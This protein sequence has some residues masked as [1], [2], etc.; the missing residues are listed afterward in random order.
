M[1]AGV[2]GIQQP[3]RAFT[4]VEL[5]VV[6]AIIAVLIGLLLPAVQSARE[7]ARRTQCGNNLRQL[8]LGMITYASANKDTFPKNRHQ[9][10]PAADTWRHWEAF[11]ANYRLL[12][13]LEE[14]ALY[15]RFGFGGT[16]ASYYSGPMQTKVA[17]FLCPSA[18]PAPPVTRISWGG[19]GC[20]YAWCN[21]SGVW[22]QQNNQDPR[23]H[24][25]IIHTYFNRRA[26]Q[27]TDGLTKTLLAAEILP[28]TGFS[29]G[30][31]GNPVGSATYPYDVFYAGE[32]AFSA[33]ADKAFPTRAE[34]AAVGAAA[35]G[36]AGGGHRG[37]NGCLWGWYALSHTMFNTAA[38]PDW[39]YPT[40]GGSCCPGGATDW[41]SNIVPPRSMHPGGVSA[42]MGDGSVRLINGS[43]DPLAF[44]RM[45]NIRD[46]QVISE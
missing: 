39:E 14:V 7:S 33:M 42:A 27:V 29:S 34:L 17:A 46:G 24:N 16:F 11:S 43:I 23:Q 19:P 15:D 28:G 4:L 36:M 1:N 30:P 12:P 10:A 20:N 22:T 25:G 8:A 3:R 37:N 41:G 9:E 2:R 40:A 5:L 32:S 18:P 35:R 38:P 6:I 26:S 31:G 44:Q 45:G 13:Y 21:G